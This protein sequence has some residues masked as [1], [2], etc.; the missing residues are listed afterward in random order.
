MYCVY[1]GV[2]L[3]DGAKECPLCHTPVAVAQATGT[4]EKT[5]YSDRLP[6]KEDRHGITLVVWLLTG[7]WHGASWNFVLWGLYYFALLMLEKLVTFPVE[8][9]AHG[10]IV[11]KKV[12]PTPPKYPRR[13]AKIKQ[14]PL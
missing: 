9:T 5:L 6:E 14:A 10:V 12:A 11:L 13:F 1:C 3:Q 2:K 8:D 4:E 7:F